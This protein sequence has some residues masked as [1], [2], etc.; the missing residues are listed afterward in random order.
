[1]RF[2]PRSRLIMALVLAVLGAAAIWSWL[3]WT[4]LS[5][6]D[7]T[8]DNVGNTAIA[9]LFLLTLPG[10]VAGLIAL[11]GAA[12]LPWRP[13]SGGVLGTVALAI[14]ILHALFFGAGNIGLLGECSK[15]PRGCGDEWQN[16]GWSAAGLLLSAYLVV[17][18]LKVSGLA[19][20]ARSA[21][22]G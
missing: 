20:Q 11:V 16:I 4:L 10:A 3:Q 5:R 19:G 2:F 1:M 8:P 18:L 12:L 13:R 6:M 9:I 7:D 21:G 15:L 14:A 17:A 22:S